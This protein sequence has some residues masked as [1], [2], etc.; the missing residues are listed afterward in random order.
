MKIGWGTG[1]AIFF[2]AFIVF[3]MVLVLL[4]SRQGVQLVTEDYYEKELEF[5]DVQ[6]RMARADQ[7]PEPLRWE[8][9]GN[10]LLLDF[11]EAA[12]VE[13]RGSLVFYN[14]SNEAKDQRMDFSTVN[15]SLLLDLGAL[16]AGRYTLK[17]EWQAGGVEY[18]SEGMLL[19]P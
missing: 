4:A 19:I 12:G 14:P 15:D 7:L 2:A 16:T 5:Q 3:M 17:V 8:L 10:T 18:Y 13:F 6:E 1:T 11:P 9:K